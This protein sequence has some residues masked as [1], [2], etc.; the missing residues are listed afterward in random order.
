MNKLL[1]G[2]KMIHFAPKSEAGFKA[3]SK[4]T[5]AKKIENKL[6]YEGEQEWADDRIVDSSNGYAGGEGTLSTLGITSEEQV[7]LFGNKKVKGGVVVKDNDEAPEGAFIFE[8]GKKGSVHKRLYVIYS[9]KCSPAGISGE[10]VE[11]GKAAAGVEEINY[12]IGSDSE[13]NIYYYVDTDDPTISPETIANWYK[14]VQLP[15]DI[16]EAKSEEENI[17]VKNK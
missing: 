12:S 5:F 10:T 16:E 13:G 9:C 4:V 7:L 6:K 17:E 14:E 1:K 15:E 3:P 11:E 8:R 2:L